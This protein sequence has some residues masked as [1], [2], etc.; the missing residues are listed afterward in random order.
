MR[1]N[2]VLMLLSQIAVVVA[3]LATMPHLT[4]TIGA[5]G[6]GIYSLSFS[7]ASVFMVIG[8]LGA[9]LYGRRE[10]AASRDK[11]SRSRLF[12]ELSSLIARCSVVVG[13]VYLFLL[14]V[15]PL[16]QTLF[17]ALVLQLVFLASGAI[18]VSWLFHG[19]ERFRLVTFSII[20]ARFINV[21]WIFLAIRNPSDTLLYVFIMA[22]TFLLTSIFPWVFVFKFV[23]RP[24]F[25]DLISLRHFR[26]L[27]HFLVPAV[28]LQLFS[29][30]NIAIIGYFL[31]T[32]EVGFYD[33]AFRLARSPIALITVVG[34]VLLPR[35]AALFAS[36]D[37]RAQELYLKRG[38]AV[39]MFMS[40]LV[41]FGLIGTS[42]SFVVIFAG[43]SFLP[44]VLILQILSVSLIT[45]GW[46]NVLRTQLILPQGL[47]RVYSGSLVSG[48]IISCLLSAV[49][50]FPFGT[51]GA[52][53]GFLVGELVVACVQ[54]YCIRNIVELKPLIAILVRFVLV[55]IFACGAMFLIKFCSFGLVQT[56]V[57]QIFVG[58]T[59]FI[60]LTL[61]SEFF[62]KDRYFLNEIERVWKK[63]GALRHR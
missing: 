9:Q 44:S 3:P 63:V 18:D 54:A 51:I 4:R 47:D 35:S 38:M 10:I 53:I 37:F 21:F 57:L 56:F 2:A 40:T 6:L 36:R 13:V 19:V 52:A 42:D 43:Q 20:A 1:V 55:G 14:M 23:H 59:I 58:S 22:S 39:T 48:L 50:I 16:E 61:L 28:S 33:L 45:I 15:M 8:Q 7:I 27:L 25:T 30:A 12:W 5:E 11:E 17:L 41:A 24:R 26:P 31:T 34:A 60:L 62:I 49:L 29:A 32:L 46:G